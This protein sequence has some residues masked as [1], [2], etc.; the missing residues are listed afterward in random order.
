MRLLLSLL[1]LFTIL[2][3]ACGQN[4]EGFEKMAINMAGKKAP[5]ISMT[6]VQALQK[7]KEKIIFLDSRE[8]KEYQVSHIYSAIW[9]GYDNI[10]WTKINKQDKKATIVIYCS[11]GYRSGKLTEQLKKK[12]Y[13]NVKNLYGGLFNWANNGGG[14]VNTKGVDTKEIHGYNK[15]WSKWVNTDKCE[16]IL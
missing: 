4:P 13:K 7:K 10:D 6:E 11:V 14:I 15:T 2:F 3:A 5:I 12:G 16:V 1:F 8:L 9:V